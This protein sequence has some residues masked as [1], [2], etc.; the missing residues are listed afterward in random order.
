MVLQR[1]KAQRAA[2]VSHEMETG[3]SDPDLP[4]FWDEIEQEVG[5]DSQ[6]HHDGRDMSGGKDQYSL[7]PGN[8]FGKG[9]G[10]AFRGFKTP[11]QSSK[12]PLGHRHSSTAND[13][14]FSHFTSAPVRSGL[15]IEADTTTYIEEE[16]ETEEDRWAREAAEAE[17]AE[18]E[19]EEA[20]AEMAS[21]VQA[22]YQYQYQYQYQDQYQH[23][24]EEEAHGR[25]GQQ[26]QQGF[27]QIPSGQYREH[28]V[29]L[30]EH[31]NER[32]GMDVDMDTVM[33]IGDELDWAAFDAMDVE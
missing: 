22:R 12:F 15:E 21:Q 24:E 17:Q 27:V 5:E 3:G 9:T 11:P 23:Q 19:A 29:V 30:E 18:L 1:Q 6:R 33:D 16:T 13:T 4:D 31:A 25:V 8:G 2:L 26:H 7:Y 32:L 14:I 10:E 28:Q 20:E